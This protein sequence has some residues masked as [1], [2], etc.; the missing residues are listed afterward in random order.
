M[1]AWLFLL[2][3]A[4][5]VVA[6]L[7]LWTIVRG[8]RV[9]ATESSPTS[10]E[11]GGPHPK[12]SRPFPAGLSF[13]PV[14]RLEVL[15]FF[16]V[17]VVILGGCVAWVLDVLEVRANHGIVVYAGL[18]LSAVSIPA[19][20]MLGSWLIVA[21]RERERAEKAAVR[22]QEKLDEPP[23][24][25]LFGIGFHDLVIH[26]LDECYQNVKLLT[27]ELKTEHGPHFVKAKE[28]HAAALR[29]LAR[30]CKDRYEKDKRLLQ[31]GLSNDESGVLQKFIDLTERLFDLCYEL[32][33]LLSAQSN[34]QDEARKAIDVAG[35]RLANFVRLLDNE[36][37]LLT[38]DDRQ[39]RA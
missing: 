23:P 18:L 12:E 29:V 20:L 8:T 21:I 26:F 39:R 10:I 35:S 33:R 14:I 15:N 5:F 30:I 9:H 7:R 22:L 19:V 27:V 1:S 11:N 6:L 34:N 28:Q 16:L 17:I 25:R 36:I 31:R 32:D 3:A 4:G 38:V 13:I 37:N 2:P 24:I